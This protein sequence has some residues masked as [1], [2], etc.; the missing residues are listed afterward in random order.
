VDP[1]I[2]GY[3]ATMGWDPV[4]G[5]GTINAENFVPDLVAAVHGH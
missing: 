4:T 2:T 5:L 1:S 3:P